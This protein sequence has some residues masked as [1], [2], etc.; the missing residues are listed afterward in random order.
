MEKCASVAANGHQK[1]GIAESARRDHRI[2][3]RAVRAIM[4]P[5]DF[6]AVLPFVSSEDT[7]CAFLHSVTAVASCVGG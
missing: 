2:S 6:I 4:E 5:H 3:L 7:R 1:R